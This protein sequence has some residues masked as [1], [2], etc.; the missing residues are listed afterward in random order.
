M[1]CARAP[2]RVSLLGGGT[3]YDQYISEYGYGSVLSFAVNKHCSVVV[4]PQ[5]ID[6]SGV[7]Y[8]VSYRQV[9]KCISVKEITHRAV[10]ESLQLFQVDSTQIH[11]IGELQAGSGVGSSSA[12]VCA[13]FRALE[14]L[15]GLEPKS[16]DDLAFAVQRFEIDSLGEC[17]GR[18]DACA[19]SF[20][21]IN[22]LE[23][24]RAKFVTKEPIRMSRDFACHF[25]SS[26]LL[27]KVGATRSASDIA[28]R[29][30]P[31]LVDVKS[32]NSLQSLCELPRLGA[33][34]IRKEDL[35][36]LGCWMRQ[37][38]D[39]KLSVSGELIPA[40]IVQLIDLG[41]QKGASAGR[42]LGAGVGGYVLFL[43]EPDLQQKFLADMR[44]GLPPQR[45]KI[46]T[47][48]ASVVFDSSNT[49]SNVE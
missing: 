34:S 36:E 33:S 31:K 32:R 44:F 11:C 7:R 42:L 40:E 38:W 2:Y 17:V 25:E 21:G 18:Q 8:T 24:D 12:F 10:R 27:V 43:V 23:F 13:L 39:H 22:I 37:A 48:G 1:I 4:S 30:V 5:P 6:A 46:Q 28:A 14:R 26:F 16:P 41:L 15:K 45:F 20:G 3:D 49:G 35:T 9:E 19:S 47:E 29:A